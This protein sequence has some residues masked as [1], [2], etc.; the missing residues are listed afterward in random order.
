MTTPAETLGM[1][2]TLSG[3]LPEV[4]PVVRA[5]LKEEGFG[6]LTEIDVQ[7]TFKQKLDV[8]FQPYKILGACNPA[9]AHQALTAT[10]EV[11]L[12]LPCNVTLEQTD[13]DT[14][15][16][17]LIDPIAMMSVLEHPDLKA[18]ADD[19]RARLKRVLVALG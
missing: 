3:T 2:V 13:A 5:A 12:L 18:V 1:T 9:L 14:V 19:A 11:G 16:V 15:R 10:G 6:I 7:G 17:S 4:E 8:D